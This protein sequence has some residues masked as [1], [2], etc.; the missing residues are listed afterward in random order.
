MNG[1][2]IRRYCG[3]FIAEIQGNRIREYCGNYL[4]EIDGALSHTEMMALIAILFA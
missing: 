2:R 4:Y 3:N 1:N